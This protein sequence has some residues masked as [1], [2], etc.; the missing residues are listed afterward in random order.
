MFDFQD[1]YNIKVLKATSFSNIYF[2]HFFT[3]KIGGCSEGQ[4]SSLNLAIQAGEEEN[5][6]KNRKKLQQILGNE[7]D[8]TFPSQIHSDKIEI[9]DKPCIGLECDA[10]V[11][12]VPN[13]PIAILTADC[14][15]ILIFD[16]VQKVVAAVH[17]G[18]RG[19][20]QLILLKTLEVMNKKFLS[21]ASGLHLAIGPC[22]SS[23]N[24]VV[25]QNV[26]DEFRKVYSKVELSEI[27]SLKENKY[28]CD[29]VKANLIQAKRF[30]IS[31]SHV[32]VSGL[33]TFDK[34]EYFYSVRRQGHACGRQAG[35]IML[36]GLA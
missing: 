24:Y 9:I 13:V 5:V 26:Y 14:V 18:W 20:A 19:T 29:L 2:T 27:F 35:V 16:E 33:C 30:G 32:H 7:I 28:Y 22:I 21:Q 36:N 4:F 17:A 8:I 1:F 23:K 3:T 25:G 12:Q 6:K 34:G 31:D 15:P 10:L 11:T